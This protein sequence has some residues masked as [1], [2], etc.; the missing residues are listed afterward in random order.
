M[1][2]GNLI[3]GNICHKLKIEG[4]RYTMY[5]CIYVAFQPMSDYMK[6]LLDICIH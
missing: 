2:K 6:H 1:I 4:E 3:Y 5:Y